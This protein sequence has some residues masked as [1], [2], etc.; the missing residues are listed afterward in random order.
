MALMA[1]SHFVLTQ[2]KT[3]LH[4]EM[5][6]SDSDSEDRQASARRSQSSPPSERN[7]N[8]QE[9]WASTASS[10]FKSRHVAAYRSTSPE[11]EGGCV[12]DVDSAG[13][14]DVRC[15][16]LRLL[17]LQACQSEDQYEE[18]SPRQ[19]RHIVEIPV[20]TQT[21]KPAT[22]TRPKEPSCPR[23]AAR[24]RQQAATATTCSE[25]LAPR[26]CPV[27]LL[28]KNIPSRCTSRD[29]LEVIA[30]SG[31]AGRFEFLYLPFKPRQS[32]NRGYAFVSFV[33]SAEAR[34]FQQHMYG[35]KFTRRCSAKELVI[36][37]ANSHFSI[38]QVQA[39][40]RTHPAESFWGPVLMPH[41]QT[42]VSNT[43]NWA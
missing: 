34:A 2:R 41:V 29:I 36:E 15:P 38:D 31:F 26:C 17:A 1:N 28:L 9:E 12:E 39:A 14:E 37:V 42:S 11:I 40:T 25:D 22:S 7:S 33:D 3:F 5:I 20:V 13:A 10:E 30:D 43:L 16:R 8:S 18:W 32:Q 23:W 19:P 24:A 4:A 21:A 27:T 6:D 35:R